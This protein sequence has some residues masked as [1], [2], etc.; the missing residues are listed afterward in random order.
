MQ[1]LPA[2]HEPGLAVAHDEGAVR[3]LVERRLV[4]QLRARAGR[5]ALAVQLQ[6]DRVGSGLAGMELAPDLAQPDVVGAAAERARPV[7]GG[8]RGHLVEEEE[9]REPPGLQL[10]PRCQPRNSSRQAIQRRVP[11]MRRMRPPSSCM[12]PRLP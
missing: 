11:Y 5:D 7:P 8:E 2:E 6:V 12:Q 9:L 4:V 10:G 1:K 3:E